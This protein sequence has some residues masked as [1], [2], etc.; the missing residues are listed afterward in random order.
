[1]RMAR[2]VGVVC[3]L[4]AMTAAGAQAQMHMMEMPAQM[5]QMHDQKRSADVRN[6]AE[7][8]GSESV[9]TPAGNVYDGALQNEGWFG[10]CVGCEGGRSLRSGEISGQGHDD[11]SD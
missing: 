3:F 9:T 7:D 10:R 4:M 2:R 1:M 5:L 6:E 8:L 11:A